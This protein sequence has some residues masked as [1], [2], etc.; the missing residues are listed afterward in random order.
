MIKI[1]FDD[2]LIDD[3]NYVQIKNEFKLFD[4]EFYLGAS[5]SNTFDITIPSTAVETIP[6][7]ITIEVDDEPYA[8][9][10]VDDYNYKDNNKLELK[11]VD[12]MVNLNKGYD[13]SGIVPCTTGDIYRNIL[14][15]FGIETDVTSFTNDDIV[16]DYYDNIIS[17]LEYMQYLA[18]LNGGY[19]QVNSSGKHE[20]KEFRESSTRID[21]NECS[22]FKLGQKH[23]IERVVFDNGL[24]KFE[25]SSDESLETLYLNQNNV[26]INTEAVFNKIANKILNFEFYSITVSNCPI[27][28][29]V[30]AG[31]IIT[32]YD[33]DGNEY[34]TIAQYSLNY[35]GGWIGGYS[36]DINSK[37]RQETKIKGDIERVKALA[38]TLDRNLNELRIDVRET[39]QSVED[40]ANS[41]ELFSVDLAQEN[42]VISTDKNSKPYNN[43]T[44]NINY[45]GY[46]KGT[47]ITPSVSIS[48]SQTGVTASSDSTKLMFTVSNSTAI[49]NK[50]FTYDVA[51]SYT[52]TD[53]GTSYSVLKK[54]MVTLALQGET[55]PA[56]QNGTDGTSTYFYVR[57]SKN[58]SGNPMVVTPTSETEYMGVATTTSPTAPTSYSAYTWSKTKGAQGIQGPSGEDGTSSYLHIKWSEDG[59]T[60]TPAE[61]GV[62]EGKTPARWQGTYVD[63]NPT[64]STVFSD[65]DWVDTSIYV[66]EE[67]NGLQNEI[68]QS[69]A[70]ISDIRTDLHNNYSTTEEINAIQ[71]HNE[72]SINQLKEEYASLATTSNQV[73]IQVGS[74]LSNGVNKIT[75]ATGYTFDENGLNISKTGTE[76]SNTLDNTGMYVRRNDEE[77]LGADTTGVRGI[78]FWAKKYLR[79]GTNS[80]LED[81]KTTRTGCFYVGGDN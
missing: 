75:T 74:I 6:E 1:Y 57:Y 73:Q 11:L 4:E 23:K 32:F 21:I 15:T 54:V 69:N 29:S 9:L 20:L 12:K 10:I 7:K 72:E 22:D 81:Y 60:F 31:D 47:Q 77:M 55:G 42:L 48:G 38:V 70:N 58:A 33:D 51:F 53:T 68:N 56:G 71:S 24:L 14:S 76:I 40:L 2:Q 61:D 66:Q 45:Y 46:F 18:E 43:A 59:E 37:Q 19:S 65:Y 64:D 67:L 41:I 13:A 16:V 50:T 52:D 36:L 3:E 63:T 8:T 49:A 17:G 25:T 5:S 80:R 26:F 78:N 44:Y 28:S 30:R 39:E 79:I 35:N 34:P 27:D 62:P